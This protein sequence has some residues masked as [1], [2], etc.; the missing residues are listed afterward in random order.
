DFAS[1][2]FA[3]SD[4]ADAVLEQ[5]ARHRSVRD[6]APDP[7]DDDTIERAVAAAQCAATSSWIQAYHL[8]QVTDADERARLAELTGGQRQV[9]EA[10]AFFV[11]A[12]DTRRHRLIAAREGK[13]YVQSLEVFL[14]AAIDA[15]LFAQ[16]LTL[17][18][19]SLGKGVCYIGGLRNDLPSVD[20]LLELPE[21]VYPL[22]GLCVGT[23]KS[24]PGTR[25]RFAPNAVWSKGRY[26]S[27][28]EVLRS[29]EA[30]DGEAS[31]YYE[32]RGAAGRNWSGGTWR[33]FAR[34]MRVRLRSYYEAKDAN[35][36]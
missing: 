25:P 2:D 29:V 1:P 24:D 14:L 6:F 7:V 22:F 5:M 36:D 16:N 17:A 13:P 12:G 30:H 33:K 11:V 26:P 8:L 27:D 34:P 35:F 18:L 4:R 20:A 9:A 21:G 10:G 31:E 3:N 32:R 19:E 23:P 15:S 28:D